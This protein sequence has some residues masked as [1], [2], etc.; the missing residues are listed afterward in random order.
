MVELG[1]GLGCLA[2][3]FVPVLGFPESFPAL[4]S[5]SIAFWPELSFGSGFG[6][7]CGLDVRVR[8]DLSIAIRVQCTVESTSSSN[9]SSFLAKGRF[10]LLTFARYLMV[11]AQH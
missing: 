7:G 6:L 4:P 10:G 3:S 2:C 1:F 5:V 9:S 8:G 11:S